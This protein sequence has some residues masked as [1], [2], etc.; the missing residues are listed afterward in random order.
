MKILKKPIIEGRIIVVTGAS[1]GV[2]RAISREFGREKCKVALI[3]RGREGLE[4]TKLE[5]EKL[6]GEALILPLDV[7]DSD[8]VGV[9]SMFG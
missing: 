1:A 3:A 8:A 9:K 4:A 5:I 2:G 7:A 6:G